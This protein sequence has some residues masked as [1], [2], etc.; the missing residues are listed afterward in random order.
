MLIDGHNI[1]VPFE[2]NQFARFLFENCILL[3]CLFS[4]DSFPWTGR[5]A[6]ANRSIAAIGAGHLNNQLQIFF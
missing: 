2:L 6:A 5:R 1:K 4:L 3:N